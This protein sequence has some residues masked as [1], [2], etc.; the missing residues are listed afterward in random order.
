LVALI[1][2]KGA[3]TSMPVVAEDPA[4]ENDV[5]DHHR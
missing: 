4:Q 2:V 1:M 5:L 3:L